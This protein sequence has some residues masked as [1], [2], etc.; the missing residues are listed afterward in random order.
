VAN[1]IADSQHRN[2]AYLLGGRL[3]REGNQLLGP[4]VVEQIQ[5]MHAD[6]AVLTIGGISASG[7]FMDFNAEEAYIARAMIA[8]SRQVTVL[9]DSTKLG[10]QALFQVC[11]AVEVNRLVTD[12]MPE[13][14]IASALRAAGVEI[15]VAGDSRTAIE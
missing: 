7:K 14:I 9:A 12:R 13:S 10:R 11:D 8:S 6:H 2:E 3:F 4:M 15:V 5:R 1:Q